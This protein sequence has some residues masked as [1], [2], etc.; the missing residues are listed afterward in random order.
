METFSASLALCAGN[1]PMPVTSPHTGQ[2]RGAWMFSLICAWINGWVNNRDA[3]DLRRNRAHYDVSV[4]VFW[5]RLHRSLFLGVQFT[6]SS[7]LV[8]AMA[9]RHRSEYRLPEP[10]MT[11]YTDITSLGL[12]SLSCKTSYYQLSWNLE[13]VRLVVIMIVSLRNHLQSSVKFNS[14]WKSL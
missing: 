2:W 6:V 7:P 10:M 5:S 9:W 14:I 3:G 12:Y 13:A 4:I 11:Q 1:S 8:E